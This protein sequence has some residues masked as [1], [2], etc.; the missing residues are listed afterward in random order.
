MI[1]VLIIF[2][3]QIS[4]GY[5]DRERFG[6]MEKVGMSNAEVK[7]TIRSQIIIVFFLP[8]ITASIHVAAAFPMVRRLLNIMYLTNVSLFVLCVIG[9]ILMFAIIYL[10]VFLVTSKTYY[11]IVGNQIS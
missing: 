4:E 10:V 1:T 9:T 11:R 6:I 5:D 8:L 7:A 2:Y 3:K